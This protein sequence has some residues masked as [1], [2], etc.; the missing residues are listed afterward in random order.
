MIA[1][2][3]IRLMIVD[4]EPAMR[5][6]TRRSLEH[7]GVRQI[8]EAADGEEA[9]QKM[10]AERVHIVIA[11]YGMPRMD[12]L[13]LL[14]MVRADAFLAKIGFI[15]LSGVSDANVVQR[16]DEL[17]ADGFVMKPFSLSDLQQRI[18]ALFRRLTGSNVAWG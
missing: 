4:D 7:I 5:R 6:L 16:A 11:D 10:R 17:G 3:A 15:M 8:F 1:A 13:Q 18:D 12:G 2:S 14:Q 9:L